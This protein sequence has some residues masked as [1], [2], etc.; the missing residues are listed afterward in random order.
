MKTLLLAFCFASALAAQVPAPQLNLTGNI[1]CQGFP[2]V[3]SGITTLAF[4]ANHTLTAQETSAFNLKVASSVSLTATRNLIYPMGRFFVTVENATTGGQ[5]LQVIGPSGTGV[6]ILNGQTVSVWNDGTNFV[7]VGATGISYPPSGIANS[8]GSAWGT[9]YST[10][11]T[12]TVLAL[13]ASAAFTGTP[14]SPTPANGTN[15]TQ[16]ATTAFVETATSQLSNDWI[17]Y[18]PSGGSAPTL[19]TY[20]GGIFYLRT[21][22]N[23]NVFGQINVSGTYTCGTSPSYQIVDLGTSATTA[24]GSATVVTSS[25]FS[26]SGVASFL[27]GAGVPLTG[28]HYFGFGYT[29][30]VCSAFPR[31]DIQLTSW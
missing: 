26:A 20:I 31:V 11:G 22:T 23:G 2:C 5:A 3:N 27:G 18:T 24:F 21:T 28:G 30:G 16:I 14:T 17:W 9:S 6:T 4:D 7:Q 29:A 25:G 12:G 1:G 13:A 10:S 8:T 15:T 19:N